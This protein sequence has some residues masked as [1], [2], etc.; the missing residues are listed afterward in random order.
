V[1]LHLREDIT[2]ME[3]SEAQRRDGNHDAVENDELCLVLHDLVPPSWAQLGD[4]VDATGEDGEVGDEETRNEELEAGSG[5]EAQA[6]GAVITLGADGVVE[7]ERS[8][9]HEGD[10]LPYDTGDHE[11]GADVLSA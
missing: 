7:D 5:H 11:I 4:T 6:A 1:H 10:D 3:N 2:G 9:T 8:E